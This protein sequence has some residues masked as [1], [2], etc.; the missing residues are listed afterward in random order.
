MH[1]KQKFG[2]WGDSVLKGVILDEVRGTY[3]LLKSSCVQ[4]VE[5]A[6][7]IQITNRTRFGFTV[8]KGYEHLKKSLDSGL[9][10]DV[11]LLEYGGND[12]DFDWVAVAADPQA[13]HQPHTPQPQFV[14]TLQAM[15]QLLQAHDIK[16]VLMSLPPISGTRY[17]DYIVSKGPDRKRLLQ[18]LGDAQQI[19]QYHEWYSL[20][21][22]R[23]AARLQCLYV[24]VR[25]AFLAEGHSDQMIC[26]DGIHPNE[27]GHLL[28]QQVFTGFSEQV[29]YGLT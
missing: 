18:F 9:D 19:Y 22:T 23:L 20:S 15:T 29:L 25:E 1:I 11:V 27:K 6:L 5:Q 28:M 17:L 13:P 21:I 3:R 8:D 16:P 7:N 12:C 24:P 2:V 10:C 26:L 4:M 14:E